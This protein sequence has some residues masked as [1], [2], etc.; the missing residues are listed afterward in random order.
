ME[1]YLEIQK[2]IKPNNLEGSAQASGENQLREKC[3]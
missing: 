3:V 2:N 1:Y